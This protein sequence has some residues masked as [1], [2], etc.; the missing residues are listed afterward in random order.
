[1]INPALG[2]SVGEVNKPKFS[3]VSNQVGETVCG[4]ARDRETV[5]TKR[6]VAEEM[7]GPQTQKEQMVSVCQGKATE[8]QP[9][10]QK[11]CHSWESELPP[12]SE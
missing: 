7:R 1:M 4:Y 6:N 5:R 12:T 8:I 9:G 2:P 10:W 3:V 11:R